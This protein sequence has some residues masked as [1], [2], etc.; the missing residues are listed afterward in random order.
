MEHSRYPRL[1]WVPACL[2]S[3]D[4]LPVSHSALCHTT[5]SRSAVMLASV[6]PTWPTPKHMPSPSSESLLNF[7]QG[8]PYLPPSRKK[9]QTG[10]G[11]LPGVPASLVLTLP[12][13]GHWCWDSDL[14]DFVPITQQALRAGAAGHSTACPSLAGPGLEQPLRQKL[15]DEWRTTWFLHQPVF[16]VVGNLFY[17]TWL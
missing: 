13:S 10:L 12:S 2:G 8:Q 1:L 3:H 16:A 7:S 4:L 15:L 17:I 11:A 5:P 9:P 6:Q 14:A